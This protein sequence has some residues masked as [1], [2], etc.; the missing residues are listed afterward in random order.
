MD[1]R[2]DSP[3]LEAAKISNLNAER[4]IF[5]LEASFRERKLSDEVSSLNDAQIFHF[6]GPINQTNCSIAIEEL[7]TW[8]RKNPESEI[9]VIFNSPGGTVF[10][11]LALFDY[12]RDLQRRGHKVITKALG[13]AESM[14]SVLLQA[15]SERIMSKNAFIMIHEISGGALGKASEMEDSV[16]LVERL[17]VKILNI[18]AERSLLTNIKIKRRWTRKDWYLDAEEAFE[19]GFIDRIEE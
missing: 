17:Q 2:Y 15:G 10:D 3:A 19:L 1:E 11:G 7:G 13:K 18:L 4:R 6:F 12:L 5:E 9:T 8:S 14:G 16:K